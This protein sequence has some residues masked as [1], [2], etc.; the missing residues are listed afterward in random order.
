MNTRTP[1]FLALAAATTLVCAGSARA[2]PHA[3]RSPSA[4]TAVHR[5]LLSDMSQPS[6]A[7]PQGVPSWYDW[8]GHPRVRPVASP[9]SFRAFTAWGQLYQCAGTS[10]SSAA[11]VQLRDLQ[12][13]V[14]PRGSST[15]RR[16]QFSSEMQGAAFA[17]NY[18]GP[19][20]PAHYVAKTSGTAVK[21]VARHNFHFW[22]SSGRVSL[23]PAQVAGIVVAVQARLQM[24]PRGPAAPCLVL[25][26]G[27]D[28]WRSLRV[29]PGGS[30]SADVGIGRF[31]RVERRW[32]LFTMTTASPELLD[33]V[34]P[35][36]IA[37]AGDDF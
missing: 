26:V 27:G 7:L 20:L 32:R 23:R 19:T 36:G 16:I 2:Q 29:E 17:E 21:P 9:R 34:P 28:L 4:T 37:P 30:N 3:R 8:A 1:R 5:L 35:P 33:R 6:E 24:Q 11:A 10:T 18:D 22:P 31:K 15:W 12:T 25:S 14:L 13:W